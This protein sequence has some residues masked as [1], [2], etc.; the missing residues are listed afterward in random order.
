MDWW[1]SDDW[2][3]S[4]EP[5]AASSGGS[6]LAIIF[7]DRLPG[8]KSL[9]GAAQTIAPDLGAGV[10][11]ALLG[12]DEAAA[13]ELIKAG[14]STV[15]LLPA[16]SGLMSDAL[17]ALLQL[18]QQQSPSAVLAES[19]ERGDALAGQLAGRLDAGL[20]VGASAVSVGYGDQ[21]VQA[22][23]PVFGGAGIA[24]W[25]VSGKPAILTLRPGVG[26]PVVDRNR[27]GN[28]ER[29][30]TEVTNN[31]LQEL[32]REAA[33]LQR[34]II[35][36]RV[37]VIG[38]R[39]VGKDGFAQLQELA[40]AMGGVVGATKSAVREG[41][42]DSSQQIGML[43]ATV[44]PDLCIAVGVSGTPEHLMGI[45]EGATIVALNNDPR[46]PI[47]QLADYAIVGDAAEVVPA[48][49]ARLKKL[50]GGN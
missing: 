21:Q 27:S 13:D 32:S 31:G 29:F 41:W 39:G 20:V 7:A 50:S 3:M 17:T 38:G 18:C 22:N 1:K 48:L 11:A 19:S 8:G 5:T 14:A 49:T 2:S 26:N 10:T 42:A 45:A 36:A 4:D 46:A 43:G 44:R 25:Q 35:R 34:E 40:A 12:G 23:Q 47:F 6:V 24:S 33:P 9:L 15:Y 28:V 37:V 16:A 30:A